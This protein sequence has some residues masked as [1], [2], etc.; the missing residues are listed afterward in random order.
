MKIDELIEKYKKQKKE[1]ENDTMNE[2]GYY[3]LVNNSKVSVLELV[4][5][6]LEMYKRESR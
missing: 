6:D 5:E 1:Y 3:R 2:L 4:I